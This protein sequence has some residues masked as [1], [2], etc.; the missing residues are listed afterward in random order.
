M[1]YPIGTVF[2]CSRP[3]TGDE[4]FYVVLTGSFVDRYGEMSVLIVW[5][6]GVVSDATASLVG[7]END[8]LL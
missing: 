4:G 3:E 2:R 7:N 5:S 1:D 6:D 8:E